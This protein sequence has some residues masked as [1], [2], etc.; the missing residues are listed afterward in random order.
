MSLPRHIPL[1]VLAFGL[2]PEAALA[3]D[4]FGDLGPFFGALL[5]PLADPAQ[6]LLLAATATLLA[7]QPVAG[8]RVAYAVLLAGCLAITLVQALWPMNAPSAQFI[9]ALAAALG[10]LALWGV[11]LRTGLLAAVAGGAAVLAGLAADGLGGDG[12]SDLLAALGGMAGTALFVLLLWAALD[13]LQD[14]LGR[15]AGAVAASWVAAVGLMVAALPVP[16]A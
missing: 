5:H 4:A 14:R 12:R 11:A 13:A 2:V 1:A 10:L 15:V 7:R 16:A 3:H 8:V 6:G 9:G